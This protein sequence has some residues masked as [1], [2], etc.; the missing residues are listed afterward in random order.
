M[1]LRNRLEK[2]EVLAGDA[3]RGPDGFADWPV[4]DQLEDVADKLH[5]FKRFHARAPVRYQ[6]T[7][8]ELHLLGLLCVANGLGEEPG[9]LP[10][11]AHEHFERM[12]PEKQPKQDRWLYDNRHYLKEARELTK[13]RKAWRHENPA[14]RVPDELIHVALAKRGGS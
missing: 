9:D 11:W 14:G 1:S 8:R 7:D 13:K 2:L 6:A 4:D 3:R 10:E 12:E 5:F